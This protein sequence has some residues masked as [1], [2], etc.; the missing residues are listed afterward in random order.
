MSKAIQDVIVIGAGVIGISTALELQSRGRNVQVIDP[1]GIGKGASF[2]NAGAFAFS[3]VLPL[4]TP[5]IMRKAPFWLFDP[6]GPLSVPPAHGLHIAPWLWKFWRASRPV[7][8][9]KAVIAQVSLMGLAR[10]AHER[11]IARTDGAHLILREGQLQLYSNKQSF[12]ASLPDWELRR[13]HGIRFDLVEHTDALARIQPGLNHSFQYGVFT[14]DWM[15]TVN[16]KTWVDHLARCFLQRGGTVERAQAFAIESQAYGVAVLT[17]GALFKAQ[18][19]V[20]AT[21]AHSKILAHSLGDDIPLETERGYNTTLPSGAFDLRTQLTFADHGF[22][23]SKLDDGVRVGGSVELGGLKAPANFKR[24]DHMLKKAAR[25]LPNLNTGGGA[26]WM[27]F[28]PSLPDSLPVIS[29]ARATRNVVYAFGH[30]HLG[31]TQSA[32]TAE[33]VADLLSKGSSSIPMAPFSA[34]RFAKKA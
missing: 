18:Q 15:N 3:D 9:A 20:V 23:V 10:A 13:Q 1:A 26:Q 14:P 30:G 8:F 27:G 34:A 2:G 33:I 28:R 12:Q 16:P 31:L 19:V 4:A 7:N 6:L 17:D 29:H 32:A 25:F 11:Q 22:V 5:R 24:A 21:G